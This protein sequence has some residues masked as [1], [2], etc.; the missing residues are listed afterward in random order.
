MVIRIYKNKEGFMIF[1]L[2]FVSCIILNIFGCNNKYFT[3]QENSLIYEKREII[4]SERD[5][6][7][8]NSDKGLIKIKLL[9]KNIIKK[10]MKMIEPVI[11]IHIN[12]EIKIAKGMSVIDSKLPLP[13]DYTYEIDIK[14]KKVVFENTNLIILTSV[15][16]YEILGDHE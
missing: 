14:K 12:K 6:E 1:Y 7:I 3:M 9:N 15:E 5:Y 13:C 16:E 4:L 2:F 8:F 10:L 11:I